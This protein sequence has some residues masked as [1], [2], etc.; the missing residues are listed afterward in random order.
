MK[1]FVMSLLLISGLAFGKTHTIESSKN[2]R[3]SWTAIG[4]PG[5]LQIDGKG[6]SVEGELKDEGGKISG[7]FTCELTRFK[8]GLKTRD[9][10]MKKDYLHVKKFPTAKL[11]LDPVE[12]GR[13]FDF[14]GKLTL[15]G[16]TK[17]VKGKG[18]LK[19][20][21][22]SN[23]ITAKMTLNLSDYNIEIPSYLGVTVAKNVD[24]EV[25]LAY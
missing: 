25:R 23:V 3:V 13:S 8:T 16:V 11:E 20:V 2:N 19:K 18:K 24:L 10:H 22:S 6:G 17:K 4:S 1:W 15:H 14:T 7:T 12:V 9:K 5:F 21:G